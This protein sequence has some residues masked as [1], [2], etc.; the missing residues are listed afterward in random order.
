MS[1]QEGSGLELYLCHSFVCESLPS[2]IPPHLYTLT[3]LEGNG[4]VLSICGQA[5]LWC[6]SLF[7]G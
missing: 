5:L 4:P 3:F 1:F 7:S 2:P 6:F